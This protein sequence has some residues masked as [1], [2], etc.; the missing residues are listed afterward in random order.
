MHGMAVVQPLRGVFEW[1]GHLE[2]Q[3]EHGDQSQGQ[4]ERAL[5]EHQ[6]NHT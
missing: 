4:V 1:R 6:S 5:R 2:Q 3:K